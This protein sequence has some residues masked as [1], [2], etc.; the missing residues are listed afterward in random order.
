M[1]LIVGPAYCHNCRHFG[2]W[3]HGA[4]VTVPFGTDDDAGEAF[5][6]SC[7]A[8]PHGIPVDIWTGDVRHDRPVEGDGG[9]RFEPVDPDGETPGSFRDDSARPCST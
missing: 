4:A 7:A 9:I 8:F 2:D 1:T 3:I 6:H 5:G